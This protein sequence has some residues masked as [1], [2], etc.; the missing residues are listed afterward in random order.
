MDSLEWCSDGHKALGFGKSY[1]QI[2]R[3]KVQFTSRRR[4]EADD[5]LP[6][7]WLV[8]VFLHKSAWGE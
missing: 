4:G 2:R 5:G 1:M 8:W 6:S 7:R 3:R